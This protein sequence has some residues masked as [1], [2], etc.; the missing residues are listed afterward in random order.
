[1]PQSFKPFQV[2]NFFRGEPKKCEGGKSMRLHE[3]L[4]Q[5]GPENLKE[6]TGTRQRAV[7]ASNRW[8]MRS[9]ER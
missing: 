5:A 8:V 7:K 3:L 1:M 4:G 9:A 2:R 6:I